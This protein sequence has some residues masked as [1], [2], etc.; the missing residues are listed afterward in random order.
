M[1][2]CAKLLKRKKTIERVYINNSFGIQNLII[3]TIEGVKRISLI[4]CT[5]NK[6]LETK[7]KN[8]VP[9]SNGTKQ[10]KTKIWTVTQHAHET[11]LP[12]NKEMSTKNTMIKDILKESDM[13]TNML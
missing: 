2:S 11:C 5:N 9:I 1:L 8:D 12:K 4:I 3:V 7:T 10:E 13:I 6:K